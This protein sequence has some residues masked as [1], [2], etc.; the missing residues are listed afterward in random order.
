MPFTTSI[1]DFSARMITIFAQAIFRFK[2]VADKINLNQAGQ[3]AALQTKGH[4]ENNQFTETL[5]I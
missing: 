3:A 4:L 2:G 5:R 1:A